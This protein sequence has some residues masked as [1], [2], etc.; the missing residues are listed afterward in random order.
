MLA[1]AAAARGLKG[2]LEADRKAIMEYLTTLNNFNGLGSKGFNA[3]G[4]G[5]KDIF[6]FEVANRRWQQLKR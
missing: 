3:Q 2:D 6:L 4:D 5:E 1:Q